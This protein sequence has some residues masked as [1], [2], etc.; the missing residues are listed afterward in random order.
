[1]TTMVASSNQ[2]WPRNDCWKTCAVPE[3]PGVIVAGSA[4]RLSMSWIWSIAAP[5]ATPGA[6]L[7]EIVTAGSLALVSDRERAGHLGHRGDR[8]ERDELAG[9]RPNEH[10]RQGV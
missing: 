8:S 10:F 5:R 4:S 7:N 3:N 1:M 2:P 9:G 6:R